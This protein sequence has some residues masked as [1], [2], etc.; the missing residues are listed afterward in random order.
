MWVELN[1]MFTIHPPVI[2]TLLGGICTIPSYGCFASD[3]LYDPCVL[4]LFQLQTL[5][6]SRFPIDGHNPEVVNKKSLKH[7]YIFEVINH[8]FGRVGIYFAVFFLVA[9]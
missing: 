9:I 4:P 3:Y 8:Y 2:I 1:V 7:I 5:R 6:I